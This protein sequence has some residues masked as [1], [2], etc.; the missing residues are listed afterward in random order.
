MYIL[1]PFRILLKME[2]IDLDIQGHFGF[3]LI[4]F[5]KFELVLAITRQGLKRESV[6][7]HKMCIY[8]PFRAP[9]KMVLI[10]YD[11]QGQ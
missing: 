4:G 3:K 6:F 7:L 11:L 1:G 2:S 5:H 9:L 8:G 10:D